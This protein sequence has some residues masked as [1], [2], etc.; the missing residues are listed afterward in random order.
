MFMT[1]L[2]LLVLLSILD[3]VEEIEGRT[4]ERCPYLNEVIIPDSVKSISFESFD[5]CP[6]LPDITKQ[7]I[8][9]IIKKNCLVTS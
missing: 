8:Q 1:S 5:E 4:F 2:T 6:S 7:R 3:G 9:E